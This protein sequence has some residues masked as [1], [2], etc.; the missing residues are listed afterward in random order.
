MARAKQESMRPAGVGYTFTAVNDKVKG[1]LDDRRP[2]LEYG[3][4]N[5]P[6]LT[7]FIAQWAEGRQDFERELYD[8]LL[9]LSILKLA[10]RQDLLNKYARAAHD[11][12]RPLPPGV[13]L[14]LDPYV[15]VTKS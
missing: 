13:G 5:D 10:E 4:E 11:D 14:R 3:L 7:H 1:Q 9:N 15:S 8:A 12:E 6:A 2:F